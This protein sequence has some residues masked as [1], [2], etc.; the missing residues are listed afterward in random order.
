[1]N[2]RPFYTPEALLE[3]AG[4]YTNFIRFE[5]ESDVVSARAAFAPL[6]SH[7]NRGLSVDLENVRTALNVLRVLRQNKITERTFLLS[8]RLLIA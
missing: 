1:M 4:N 6:Q 2:A 7:G 5:T 8:L 3:G